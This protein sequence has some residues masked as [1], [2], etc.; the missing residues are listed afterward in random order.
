MPSEYK[1][2]CT[3]CE[4]VSFPPEECGNCERLGHAGSELDRMRKTVNDLIG[5]LD[6]LRDRL[7]TNNGG[8]AIDP[9]Q[10]RGWAERIRAVI[11]R[12]TE[13]QS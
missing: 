7:E 13:G 8:A 4:E 11:A 3:D 1:G 10:Q 9:I 12:A 5:V 2:L 6:S